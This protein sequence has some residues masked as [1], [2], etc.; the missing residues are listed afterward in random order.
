MKYRQLSKEQ[1]EALNK[2]FA[3]FLATQQIDVNEWRVI[4]EQKPEVADEEL[5]LFSDLVWDEALTKTSY[6]EHFSERSANLF[7]CDK[8]QIYRLVVQVNRTPFNFFDEKDYQ[9]FINNTDD[10]SIEFMRGKKTY[11][12]DRNQELFDLIEKGGVISNGN[13]YEAL[14]Q[15]I[16]KV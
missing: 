11:K 1:F 16:N 10:K 5:R 2:E 13:L 6:I 15:L 8:D 14:F 9:W 4:K 7:K 12:V 3:Q